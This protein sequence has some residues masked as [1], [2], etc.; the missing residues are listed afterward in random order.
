MN[1]PGVVAVGARVPS[2]IPS[3]KAANMSGSS[4]SAKAFELRD[5]PF[6]DKTSSMSLPVSYSTN[7]HFSYQPFSMEVHAMVIDNYAE[8]AEERITGQVFY[9]H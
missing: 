2:V 5:T 8:D 7:F 1:N 6:S 9:M 4:V 3:A